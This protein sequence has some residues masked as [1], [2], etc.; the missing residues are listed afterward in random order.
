MEKYYKVTYGNASLVQDINNTYK[1]GEVI[2][3]KTWNPYESN[4]GGFTFYKKDKIF[5][6]L[7]TGNMLYEVVPEDVVYEEKDIYYSKKIK[8]LNPIKLTDEL[9]LKIY[10]ESNLT[11]KSYYK[12]LALCAINNYFKTCERIIED[13]VSEETIED[14]LNEYEKFNVKNLKDDT[15]GYEGYKK[16][17][18]LLKNNKKKNKIRIEISVDKEPYIKLISKDKVINITG[19]QS[20]GKSYFANDYKCD[21]DYIIICTDNIFGD[22]LLMN[23][24]EASIRLLMK[25]K[26]QDKYKEIIKNDFDSFYKDVINY[27]K[28]T[29]KTIVID[30]SAFRYVK[31]VKIL[32]GKIIVMRPSVDR[33]Y[34]RM[35]EKYKSKNPK[36]TKVSLKQYETEAKKIYTEYIKI[37]N[38]IDNIESL[39]I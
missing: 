11:K 12:C 38:L 19:E 24:D 15:K 39:D 30:S 20:S 37:N 26:Y 7:I 25:E 1:V 18:N 13:Y 5:K 4:K 33:C 2:E 10:E 22:K 23:A 14:I 6:Y 34:K 29:N 32:K 9:A 8:Y 27:F 35:I 21:E 17:Y 3:S 28:N 36:Y 31:D 16:V